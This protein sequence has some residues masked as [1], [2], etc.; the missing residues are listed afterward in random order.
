M[1]RLTHASQ[2]RSL[3]AV[4]AIALSACGGSERRVER[5]DDARAGAAAASCVPSIDAPLTR[6][7]PPIEPGRYALT[8]VATV[9]SR[10]G[11]IGRGR[12]WLASTSSQDR[13]PRTGEHPS[14]ADTLARPTYGATDIDFTVVG[15][16]ISTSDPTVPSPTSLDPIYPGVLQLL[17][18]WDS[19]SPKQPILVIGTL[20]NRRAGGV[21]VD[22]PGIGL[23][24]RRRDA[25]SFGGTWEAFGRLVDG[26]GYFCARRL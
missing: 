23:F 2:P 14:E 21:G 6:S 5:R 22:G 11:S 26:S 10:R 9:G 4:F 8:L 15:A 1:R 3:L 20:A 19:D 16:P 7:I 18:N 17:A 24:V 12:L 25:A 13:S